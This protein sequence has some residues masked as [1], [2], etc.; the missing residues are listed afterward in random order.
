MA[1]TGIFCAARNITDTLALLI[2]SVVGAVFP[3]IAV[4]WKNSIQDASMNYEQTLR[5]FTLFGVAA[6]CGIFFL[7][8]KIVLLLY[9]DRYVESALCLRILIYAFLLNALSGPV[10]MFLIVTRD[11]LKHYIP[12]ALAITLVNVVLNT[13]LTPQYGYTC[14]SLIAVLTALLLFLS[15]MVVLKDILPTRPR[16]LRI[17]WR[18]VLAGTVMGVVLHLLRSKGLAV[19]VPLGFLVYVVVL[20]LLGEFSHDYRMATSYLRKPGT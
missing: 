17:S 1:E 5:F 20:T 2:T 9:K 13:W 7:S 18:S 16:W 11:R 15:K 14:A 19:L 8:E 4:R 10:G 12:Y 3:F 6:A